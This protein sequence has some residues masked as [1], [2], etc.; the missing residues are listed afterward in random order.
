[1]FWLEARELRPHA[2]A[3]SVVLDGVSSRSPSW[4]DVFRVLAQAEG[5]GLLQV[6]VHRD[7]GEVVE[8]VEDI[9]ERALLEDLYVLAERIRRADEFEE[10][11]PY[12]SLSLSL[13]LSAVR[14]IERVRCPLD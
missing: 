10:E 8:H 4:R 14:V 6:H 12:L 3:V 1:M 13:F 7:V 11:E 9:E 5:A 2:E